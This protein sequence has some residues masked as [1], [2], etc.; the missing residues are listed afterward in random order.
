MEK[1]EV[2][3]TADQLKKLWADTNR[4]DPFED[5]WYT[6]NTFLEFIYYDNASADIIRTEYFD[7]IC[8][9]NDEANDI[10]EQLH[11]RDRLIEKWYRR[12]EDAI[13]ERFNVW[14]WQNHDIEDYMEG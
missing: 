10:L 4:N 14:W 7:F 2:M 12:N 5:Y 13:H 1:I 3:L 8:D 9:N 6:D 11:N